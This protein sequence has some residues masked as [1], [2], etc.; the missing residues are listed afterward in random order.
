MTLWAP[1]AAAL[2][3]VVGT[4]AGPV[5]RRLPEPTDDPAAA[6]KVAYAKLATPRFA[7]LA[8]ALA[9]AAGL[10]AFA[11]TPTVAW[12]AWAALA[13]PGALA[14][15]VDA[16]TTWLPRVLTHAGALW[17]AVGVA[18]WAAVDQDLWVAVRAAAGAAAVGGFFFAF[19]RVTGGIG[20]G[21]VRLMVSV[22]AVTAATSVDTAWLAVVLGSFVGAAWGL[23]RRAFR[24]PGPFAYGP[25]LWAG[26]FLA[27]AAERLLAG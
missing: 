20:F 15:A 27:L 18:T 6:T 26:P 16:R 23:G 7:L 10:T 8:A 14:A 12:L 4:L 5:L 17:T 13:G 19:W 25:S 3:L 2:A 1:A 24:P 9:L 22:G 11:L 21:D